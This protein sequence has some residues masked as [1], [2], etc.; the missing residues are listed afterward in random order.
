MLACSLTVA[1]VNYDWFFKNFQLADQGIW[2]VGT[3]DVA[4]IQGLCFGQPGAWVTGALAEPETVIDPPA[5]DES[6]KDVGGRR[7]GGMGDC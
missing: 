2:L 5:A 3:R 1:L 7:G 6:T 4:D